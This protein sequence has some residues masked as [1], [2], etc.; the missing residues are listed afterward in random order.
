MSSS[1]ADEQATSTLG[2]MSSGAV[3]P[4]DYDPGKLKNDISKLSVRRRYMR[5]RLY[6]LRRE[7]I[8]IRNDLLVAVSLISDDSGPQSLAFG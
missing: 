6:A 8:K 3:N 1:A 7:Y 4:K 2:G 5:S